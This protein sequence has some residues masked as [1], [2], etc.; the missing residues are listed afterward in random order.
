MTVSQY[1]ST[2]WCVPSHLFWFHHCSCLVQCEQT[3]A[4]IRQAFTELIM[5]SLCV[6]KGYCEQ[7]PYLIGTTNVLITLGHSWLLKPDQQI[8]WANNTI[9]VGRSVFVQ[10]W[11]QVVQRNFR[12]CLQ[13]QLNTWTLNLCSASHVPLYSLR[14][15]KWRPWTNTLMTLNLQDLSGMHCPATPFSNREWLL[16][17]GDQRMFPPALYWLL[18]SQQH[19]RTIIHCH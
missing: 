2:S 12:I 16:L 7:I 6:K 1:I 8:E 5:Q 3:N 19:I 14:A 17:C 18:G 9:T 13:F 4:E 10:P 11:R 15:P